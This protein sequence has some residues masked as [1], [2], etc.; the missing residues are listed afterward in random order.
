MAT[1]KVNL[2]SLV[3]VPARRVHY[4]PIDPRTSREIFLHHALVL[5][6]FRTGAEF[7]RHN[8]ALAAEVQKDGGQ[9]TRRKEMLADEQQRYKFFDPRIPQ[10]IYNGPLFDR[11]APRRGL[12]ENPRLLF[13]SPG[14]TSWARRRRRAGAGRFTSRRNQAGGHDALSTGLPI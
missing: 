5:E 11:W 1:E 14:R 9:G 3:I 12:K 8:T 13:M 10:G 6:E 7:F 2:Y 4:G